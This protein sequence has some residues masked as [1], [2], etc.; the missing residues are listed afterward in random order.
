[1]LPALG[2]V[3]PVLPV[4]FTGDGQI[5]APALEAVVDRLAAA[6]ADG[7]VF[8]G[9]ASE[10]DHLTLDERLALIARVG[11]AARGRLAFIVGAGGG[12]D[13][14][15]LALAQA[16]AEAGA[17][18]AMIMT[19]HRLGADVQALVR[20][21]ALIRDASGLAPLIQNAPAPMGLGLGVEAIAAVAQG[22]GGV[23]Y[24]KEE[25]QPC[26]QRISQILDQAPGVAGV[27]GGAGGRYIVD[28]LT[29]GAVGTMPAC[30]L[31]E[32]HVALL[33]AHAAGDDA[34]ARTLYERMLPILMMQAIFRWRLTKAVLVERGWIANDSTRAPGP[35]LDA[36][37]HVE[38]RRWLARLEDLLEHPL[39]AL[40]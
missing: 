25:T 5:D 13:A 26:G 32:A 15:S 4:L 7:V 18:A 23:V 35:E 29:R 10:Y 2:G 39:E 16:G 22:L 19:P 11:A 33:R 12:S 37:D 3:Y 30:E 6:G 24:I 1:M 8:P 40:A 28:E 20:F 14:E 36:H 27:F 9:L 21:Y 34:L 38:L 17:V 31:A